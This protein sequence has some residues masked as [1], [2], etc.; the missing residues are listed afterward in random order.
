MSVVVEV[1]PLPIEKWHKKEGKEAFARPKGSQ[2]L[3][4]PKTGK[5]ATGLTEEESREWG[6]E[7]GLDLSDKFN[8]NEEHPTW[9]TKAFNIRLENNTMFFDMSITIN[10]IKVKNMKACKFIANSLKE[11]EDNKWPDATHYIID[12][13]NEADSKAGKLEKK[14]KA[15]RLMDKMTPQEKASMI[16]ILNGKYLKNKSNN[17]IEVEL[18]E[19]IEE[20]PENLET[21]LRYASM[22][23][24]DFTLTGQ[25]LEALHRQILTKESE[26]VYYHGERIGYDVADA[27]E[28]FKNADNQKLKVAILEKLNN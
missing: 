12:E 15:G 17:L 14:R 24:K 26:A 20:S 23:G 27:V 9:S 2:V 8:P 6:N 13:N 5:Y 7:L 28:W 3:Y 25:V 16:L 21:F 22:D 18:D 19:A 4:D 10:K 11:W 1:K